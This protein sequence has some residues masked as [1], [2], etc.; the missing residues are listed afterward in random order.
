MSRLTPGCLPDGRTMHLGNLDD[1]P[2][3]VQPDPADLYDPPAVC[4]LCDGHGGDP[5][6]DRCCPVCHGTG[7]VG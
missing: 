7:E 2:A 4:E 5:A 6:D 1:W 3:E